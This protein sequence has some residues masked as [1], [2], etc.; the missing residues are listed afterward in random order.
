MSKKLLSKPMFISFSLIVALA[1]LSLFLAAMPPG[2]EAQGPGK[3]PNAAQASVGEAFTYQGYLK[4]GSG[5]VNDTCDFQF[6]LYDALTGGSQIGATQGASG[7]AV[8]DG[9]FN[10]LLNSGNEFGATAFQGEAR[11]LEI[12]VSCSGNTQTLSPRVSL[13]PAPYAL[14]LRPGAVISGSASTALKSV[15]TL[16]SGTPYGIYGLASGNSATSYGVYGKSDSS[17]GT[18]VGG[19]APMNGVYGESTATSGSNSWG[20]YGKTGSADGY[21]VYGTAPGS[22]YGVYGESSGGHGVHGKATP[23]DG[24]AIYSEGNTMVDGTLFWKPFTSAISIPPAAFTPSTDGY[25]FTN[26]G[27]SLYITIPNVQYWLAPVQLPQGATATEL[28]FYWTNDS[29]SVN[30]TASLYRT[31]LAGHE[32]NIATASTSVSTGPAS[33]SANINNSYAKIDNTQYNYYIYLMLRQESG[34]VKAHGVVISYTVY[35]PY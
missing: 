34:A 24:Y 7:V 35:Q 33:S 3:D 10:A 12:V 23:P 16:N 22:G 19:K 11:Y 27:H 31:D 26:D 29:A 6:S 2:A 25:A 20:V 32:N 13:T 21:G 9:K 15:T 14:T 28:T 5:P 18:G 1:A 17:L 8:V 4:D 30:G